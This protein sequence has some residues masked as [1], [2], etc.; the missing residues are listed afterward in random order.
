MNA[1]AMN[2][3]GVLI[4]IEGIDGT[5]K[6]T[7]LRL[8]AEELSRRGFEVVA[9]REPTNGPHGRRIRE[10]YGNRRQVSPDEEL[11]LFMADRRQHVREVIQPALAAGKIVLTDRYYF[12]TAAY[13]GA[14]GRDPEVIL[15]ANEAF[16]PVPDLLFLLVLPPALGIERIRSL[17]REQ[18]NDFEQE[19]ELRR[20]AA[21]FDRLARPFLVRLD[22]A[23]SVAE[24]QNRLLAKIEHFL[25]E[26]GVAPVGPKRS[27]TSDRSDQ[28]G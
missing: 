14:A 24:I 8:L 4:A 5:G 27:D 25:A 28:D 3:T 18:L 19:H 7:Q 16:A 26:R 23:E 9:T 22:A 12:S 2:R 10:L 11:E 21:I 6:S 15:R 17:R 1:N 20:V 13:Q